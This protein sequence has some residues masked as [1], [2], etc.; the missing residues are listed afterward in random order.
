M[1]IISICTDLLEDGFD[2]PSPWYFLLVAEQRGEL[3][4]YALCNRAYSSW[5]RRAF[6]VEDVYVPPQHR[7]AGVGGKLFKEICRV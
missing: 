3:V 1:V 7:R 5:T 2:T 4:G 6:Y